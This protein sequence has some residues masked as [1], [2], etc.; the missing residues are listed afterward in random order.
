MS[1]TDIRIKC[2]FC[3]RIVCKKALTTHYKTKICTYIRLKTCKYKDPLEELGVI[4]DKLRE[5]GKYFDYFFENCFPR[6]VECFSIEG[7]KII[8]D[9]LKEY[10]EA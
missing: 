7:V 2:E 5:S 6:D 4:I 1:L 8:S 10:I 9:A 3:D